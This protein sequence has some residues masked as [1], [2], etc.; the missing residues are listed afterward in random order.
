MVV[1]CDGADVAPGRGR[2]ALSPYGQGNMAVE[3]YSGTGN[4]FTFVALLSGLVDLRR[5][6]KA[7]KRLYAVAATELFF[8]KGHS[9]C[10][11]MLVVT[12]VVLCMATT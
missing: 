6:Q 10:H 11:E 8:M 3:K 1:P 7:T 9:A 5:V 12:A 4:E 2:N